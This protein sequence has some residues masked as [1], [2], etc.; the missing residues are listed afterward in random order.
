MIA[1]LN[2]AVISQTK[3]TYGSV[4]TPLSPSLKFVVAQVRHY[5]DSRGHDWYTEVTGY[6]PT[7]AE[8]LLFGIALPN[9]PG[10]I[11]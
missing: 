5:G 11:R 10:A 2:R 8:N 4:Q 1:K 6:T 3:V 9:A 7:Y